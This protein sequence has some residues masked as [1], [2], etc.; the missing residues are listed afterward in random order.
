MVFTDVLL[1]TVIGAILWPIVQQVVDS[2]NRA[3]LGFILGGIIGGALAWAKLGLY[4]GLALGASLG[5]NVTPFDEDIGLIFLDALARTAQGAAIGAIIVL[6]IRSISFVLSGA[7]IGLLISLF[8]SVGLRLL[9]QT[10]LTDPL[11]GGQITVIV[12]IGSFAAFGIL[13]GRR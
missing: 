8:L 5:A 2:M 6:S 9:N 13:S 3:I 1:G 4:A 11:T 7:G 12:L 10:L